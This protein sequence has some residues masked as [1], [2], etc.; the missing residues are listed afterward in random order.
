MRHSITLFFLSLY[1]LM[2]IVYTE[3]IVIVENTARDFEGFTC[4]QPS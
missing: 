2:H 3:N 1:F 4:I